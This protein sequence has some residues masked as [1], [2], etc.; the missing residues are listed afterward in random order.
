MYLSED[1]EAAGAAFR[2]QGW[3]NKSGEPFVAS[4]GG[5]LILADLRMDVETLCAALTTPGGHHVTR[6]RW[7]GVQ[8]HG[9]LVEA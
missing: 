3:A 7:K 5:G 8:P 2:S 9:T 4:R 6:A 1:D